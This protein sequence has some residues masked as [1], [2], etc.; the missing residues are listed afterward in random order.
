MADPV[1]LTGSD[2]RCALAGD[3]GFQTVPALWK[4]LEA[5]GWLRSAQ[6]VDLSAVTA[7]DS[8]GLALLVAWRAARAREG[9]QLRFEAMP[10]RL[11]ALAQLTDAQSLLEA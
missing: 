2:G 7:A 8:A 11:H 5:D 1:Q 10:G 3:L 6:V 4:T 9:G